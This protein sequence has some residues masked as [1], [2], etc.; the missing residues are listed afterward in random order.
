MSI[1]NAKWGW[2]YFNKTTPA[3]IGKFRK[4]LIYLMSGV[5]VIIPI[6]VK[7]TNIPAETIMQWGGAAVFVLG[8]LLSE[9]WGVKITGETVPSDEVTEVK[10]GGLDT[11]N[12][13]KN[14]N[15]GN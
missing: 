10:T 15:D 5:G 1:G 6:I 13:S 8:G 14:H 2:S 12:I 3:F 7:L 4:F 9:F 11:E